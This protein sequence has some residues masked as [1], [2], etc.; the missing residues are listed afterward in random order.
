MLKNANFASD[1]VEKREFRLEKRKIYKSAVQV[2]N[3]IPGW[4]V[5]VLYVNSALLFGLSNLLHAG[6]CTR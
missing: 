4:W 1:R 6:C 5:P 3:Q 2:I